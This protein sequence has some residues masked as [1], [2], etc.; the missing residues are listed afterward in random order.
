MKFKAFFGF[1][2][3]AL[4]FTIMPADAHFVELFNIGVDDFGVMTAC[5][6]VANIV[7]PCGPNPGGQ[8]KI[9]VIDRRDV[10][11]IPDPAA[12]THSITGPIVPKTGK[13]FAFWDF[14]LDT[15]ELTSESVGDQGNQSTQA[16]VGVYI[17]RSNPVVD[18]IINDCYN[19]QYIVIV[20][21]ALG[22]KKIGGSLKRGLKFTT[23]YSSGKK[24]DDKNGREV[25][26]AGGMANE[27]YFYEGA[28]PVV[29]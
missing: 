17:P 22:Q 2:M 23:K 24:F 8:N 19:G 26:F 6:S 20:E 7:E 1:L 13:G 11:S 29:A 9:W 15:G 4:L 25:G 10:E 12:G 18:K 5:I 16:G 14:A 3:L 21:D 27:P 28:I